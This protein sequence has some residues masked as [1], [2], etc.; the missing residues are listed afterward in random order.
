[1]EALQVHYLATCR[2][3]ERV[4]TLIGTRPAE[5]PC[6]IPRWAHERFRRLVDAKLLAAALAFPAAGASDFV[7]AV[8][9]LRS[10]GVSKWSS[11]F[12]EM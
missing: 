10:L 9:F 8:E 5:E 4:V 6:Q 3:G 7:L 11:L 1:M 12:R 2:D